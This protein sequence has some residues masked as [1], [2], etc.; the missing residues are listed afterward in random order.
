MCCHESLAFLSRD[1]TS[2]MHEYV[3]VFV[4]L[5]VCVSGSV[6]LLKQLHVCAFLHNRD[7]L[8]VLFHVLLS[9]QMDWTLGAIKLYDDVFTW[10]FVPS[11]SR[12]PLGPA[13]RRISS[14][15]TFNRSASVDSKLHAKATLPADAATAPPTPKLKLPFADSPILP[16]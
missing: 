7:V 15:S 12:S 1:R 3:C 10:C 5:C 6:W 4:S 14:M 8:H 11:G 16:G 2:V 13:S 9:C